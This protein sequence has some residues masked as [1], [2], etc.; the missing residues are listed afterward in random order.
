MHRI[1]P[2]RNLHEFTNDEQLF[3]HLKPGKGSLV[4]GRY[5]WRIV[6]RQ[7]SALAR[8]LGGRR[9]G[10]VAGCTRAWAVAPRPVLG[11]T[12]ARRPRTGDSSRD[13]EFEARHRLRIAMRVGR[14]HLRA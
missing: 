8:H 14:A 11:V 3:L 10:G 4:V 1:L 2:G 12:A 6:A 13:E 9:T 7:G 5:P